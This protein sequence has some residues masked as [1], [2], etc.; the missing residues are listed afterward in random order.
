MAEIGTPLTARE[1]LALALADAPVR[2][3]VLIGSAAYAPAAA[4][5]LDIVIT[6]QQPDQLRGALQD[7]LE[8]ATGRRVDLILR[9]PHEDVGS[10]ALAILAGEVIAGHGETIQEA[11]VFFEEAGG[12]ENSFKQAE[13]CFLVAQTNLQWAMQQPDPEARLRYTMNAFD[14]LF[15]AA[16]TAALCYLGRDSAAWGKVDKVLP[17]PFGEQFTALSD[18]PHIRYGYEGRV[19]QES[20]DAEFERWQGQVRTFVDAMREK[21]ADHQQEPKRGRRRRPP[22]QEQSTAR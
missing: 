13:A 18:T 9:R 16:R 6:L 22:H 21:V 19:P 1:A 12:V 15:H 10:L 3:A 4:R 7:A 8:D 2:D 11:L 5:D 20:V 17:P 14:E